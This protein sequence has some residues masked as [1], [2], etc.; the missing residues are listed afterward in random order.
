MVGALYLSD[1][2]THCLA[3]PH[4]PGPD[5]WPRV[6][7]AKQRFVV[8]L[9]IELHTPVFKSGCVKRS[10]TSRL[11]SSGFRLSTSAAIPETTGAAAD[12]PPNDDV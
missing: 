6:Y 3:A 8:S 10:R 4:I 11:V 1:F 12:V 2:D 9:R 5:V 7:K